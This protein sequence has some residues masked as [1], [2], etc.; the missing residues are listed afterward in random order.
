MAQLVGTNE[1]VNYI[2]KM[3]HQREST[4]MEYPS[5]TNMRGDCREHHASGDMVGSGM[6]KA[7]GGD[8]H[9]IN[10]EMLTRK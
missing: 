4:G 7:M 10:D 1:G 3:V 6:K 2:K 8:T 5:G 9:A